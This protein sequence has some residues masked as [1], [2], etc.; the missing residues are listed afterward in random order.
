MNDL[1]SVQE[2]YGQTLV[3]MGEKNERIVVVE[4]DMMKASGS[5]PFANRFPERHFQVGVAEQNLIGVAAGL[6][7]SGFIPFASSFANF[8][9]KRCCDQVSISVAYNKFNVKI[10]GSYAGLTTAKNGGTHIS[11]E[12]IAIYRCMPNMVVIVPGD[13][14]ELAQSMHVMADYEG[15]V[16]LRM[17]RG[18]M[19]RIFGD[20][21]IFVMGR[22]YL[23][24]DG[25]DATI[26]ST[27]VMTYE[28]IRAIPKLK[29]EG[30]NVR[31]VHLPTIKP[32]D[33]ELILK[34]AKETGA[35]VTVENHSIL[36]GLGGA[37][38]ELL[39]ENFPVLLKRVGIR[40]KFGETATFE[41]LLENNGM[42]FP[43]IVQA[44]KDVL[45]Q[46]KLFK[47]R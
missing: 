15:P 18:P 3:E 17:A 35:I 31:H 26:I 34:A 12:D 2:V 36:G 22:G 39:S 25:N 30:I 5:H 29:E 14:V 44:V 23:L 20:D 16:Y 21:H 33:E 42:S 10:C 38:A 41:W 27:G 11:V 9:S 47:R 32:L 4:A 46:K 40:D 45:G 43:F 24:K 19:P 8:I 37:V 13:T 7:A 28:S 6:A 1:I